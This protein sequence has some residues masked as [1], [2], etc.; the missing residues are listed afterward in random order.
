LNDWSFWEIWRAGGFPYEAGRWQ[1]A[2]LLSPENALQNVKKP[3]LVSVE[4]FSRKKVPIDP[5]A[6][7]LNLSI[8]EELFLRTKATSIMRTPAS[9]RRE[10]ALREASKDRIVI[11]QR[12]RGQGDGREH[13]KRVEIEDLW[14]QFLSH[15]DPG[16]CDGGRVGSGSMNI[17]CFVKSTPQAQDGIVQT[18]RKN[19]HLDGAVIQETVGK[20]S[21][22]VWPPDFVGEF[23]I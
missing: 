14:T 17:F 13:D 1:P 21:K 11:Q 18:Q 2:G 9:S 22:V 15:A 19:G 8:A 3:I 6:L 12:T 20:M 7:R 10:K 4:H 16:F 23:S 5:K